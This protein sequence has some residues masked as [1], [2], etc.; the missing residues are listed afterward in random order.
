M[1]QL[2]GDERREIA[3]AKA[4]AEERRRRAFL[5]PNKRELCLYKR[6]A[7]KRW[8][9]DLYRPP[10]GKET[11]PASR[12]YKPKEKVRAAYWKCIDNRGLVALAN[13]N[14]GRWWV[15][16]S[17]YTAPVL[18]RLFFEEKA[19]SLLY[20]VVGSI[21][22]YAGLEKEGFLHI[23]LA[24]DDSL[25]QV[26]LEDIRVQLLEEVSEQKVFSNI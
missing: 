5:P 25:V 21:V 17:C 4:E 11:K 24:R 16:E 19:P 10:E 9:M 22:P 2:T 1:R 20:E 26:C 8:S 7:G 15:A 3:L 6:P 12:L 13:D 18:E 14:G 23:Q